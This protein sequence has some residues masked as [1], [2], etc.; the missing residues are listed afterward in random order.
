M[1]R[2]NVTPNATPS[3]ESWLQCAE[4]RTVRVVAGI[5]Y[6]YQYQYYHY[7]FWQS[8]HRHDFE[9]TRSHVNIV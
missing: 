9:T 6:M 4:Y 3:N 1:W 2:S 7:H 5:F 8:S